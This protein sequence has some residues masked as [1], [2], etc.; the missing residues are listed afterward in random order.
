MKK[1]I[2]LL[3]TFSLAL[4]LIS[5]NIKHSDDPNEPTSSTET[6]VNTA[7][8]PTVTFSR[9]VAVY[10]DTV[11]YCDRNEGGK[12]KYQSLNNIQ[13]TG[14]PL[15]PSNNRNIF[16]GVESGTQFIIDPISTEKNGGHPILYI[17]LKKG[18]GLSGELVSFNTKNNE[19]RILKEN[20][21]DVRQFLLY[22]EYLIFSTNEG[23]SG[24]TI[25]SMKTDGTDFCTLEN[26]YKYTMFPQNV[27]NGEIYFTKGRD[28]YKAPLSLE[29]SSLVAEKVAD[30][31]FFE[32]G[33]MYYTNVGTYPDSLETDRHLFRV[34]LNHASEKQSVIGQPLFGIVQ[35]SLFLYYVGVDGNT[36]YL[37]N[38]E[39]NE[40]RAV[41]PNK[42]QM[43]LGCFS[44]R[45]IC[46][47][48]TNGEKSF[49]LY[50][51]M[52][53]GKEIQIPY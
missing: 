18:Y 1:L 4:S 11:F 46:F 32:G 27:L 22:G 47:L 5:C 52:K 49:L 40:S 9:E 2:S 28:L 3:L 37:Y 30:T 8:A 19:V 51:D 44:D 34:D 35:D 42:G 15:Y 20:T 36:V 53:T 23:T 14:T 7:S 48:E 21:P 17:Y 31:V 50:Y 45:Y 33:Y 41:Y 13:S 29:S 43:K 16:S 12:I 39:T 25:H 24:R 6:G 38:A 26:R 10:Q